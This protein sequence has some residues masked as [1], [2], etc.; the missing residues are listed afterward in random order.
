MT[1]ISDSTKKQGRDNRTNGK[2]E[3]EEEKKRRKNK[4]E[5]R[6]VSHN[7]EEAVSCFDPLDVTVLVM[8]EKSKNAPEVFEP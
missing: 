6:I 4:K 7:R 1:R 8:V 5:L 2:E 3:E